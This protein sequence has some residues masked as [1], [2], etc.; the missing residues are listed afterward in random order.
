MRWLPALLLL[1][2]LLAATQTSAGAEAYAVSVGDATATG[3]LALPLEP[4]AAIV[5]IAH[6]YGHKAE[7]HRGH[8]ERLAGL[9]YAAVAMD[10]RGEGFPLRAGADDTLAAT[11]D[12]RARYPGVPVVLYSVSMGTAVAGMVLAER[13]VFDLWIN[14]EGLADLA[15]LHTEASLIA[16][17]NAFAAKAVADMEAEC[18]GPPAQEPACYRERSAMLRAAEFRNLQG[19]I[20]THGVNDGLVPYDQGR[21]M[22]AALKA[23]AIPHDFYTVLRGA[24]GG[25]GTTLTGY[26]GANVD[27]LAGHGTE[28][29]DGHT[30]TSLSFRLL[31]EALAGRLTPSGRE[32]VVDRDLADPLP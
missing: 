8:V 25:Q 23:A 19:V 30:L 13:P 9:G 4:P 29:E 6:G 18:G 26:A 1:A 12:L 27:G 11:D 20:L 21:E 28:S 7:S 17:G 32:R 16:P 10:Y 2:P 15:E 24:Q 22:Q 5:V 14:N 31:E 3:L